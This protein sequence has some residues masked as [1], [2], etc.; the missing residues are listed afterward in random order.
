MAPVPLVVGGLAEHRVE[1][2]PGVGVGAQGVAGAEVDRERGGVGGGRVQGEP[3]PGERGGDRVGVLAVAVGGGRQGE[4][5][6]AE[7]G[8][9]IEHGGGDAGDG[10]EQFGGLRRGGAELAGVGLGVPGEELFVGGGR[11]GLGGQPGE[12]PGEVELGGAEQAGPPGAGGAVRAVGADAGAGTGAGAGGGVGAEHGA[13]GVGEGAR[14]GGGEP[15]VRL[16]GEGGPAVRFAVVQQQDG[17]GPGQRGGRVAGR[18]AQGLD[19]PPDPLQQ[20]QFGDLALGPEP[21]LHLGESEGRAAVGAADG[22]REV[23]VAAAPVA[24]GGAA[25]PGEAGD[26]DR[27]HLGTVRHGGSF[28]GDGTGV[29]TQHS[30]RRRSGGSHVNG[31][32]L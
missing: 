26:L 13:G 1:G 22:A 3:E 14:Q 24:D 29:A 31:D 12:Q 11:A 21:G 6:R 23:G 20:R 10:G 16:V 7:A 19:E 30:Q 32:V 5:Q 17:A 15:G 25:H 8:G 9:G 27:G 4:Q 28:V 18:V 2:V